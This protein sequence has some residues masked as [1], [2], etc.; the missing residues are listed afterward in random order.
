MN[1]ILIVSDT[2]RRDH[3][4]CY[5]NNWISTPNIDRFAKGSLVF[6]DAYIG[7][8]PTVPNRRD[9]FT[10]KFTFVYSDWSPLTP[11]EVVLSEVLGK[12]G[13]IS[14]FIADTPHTTAPGYNYRRVSGAGPI[15]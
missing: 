3:L 4:G 8:F 5:G 6:E 15:I 9:L 10:G 13:Y 2:L 14:M 7:S 11:E 1:V 12:E